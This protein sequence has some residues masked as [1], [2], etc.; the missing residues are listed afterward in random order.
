M[1]LY[2]VVTALLSAAAGVST[3]IIEMTVKIMVKAT[4]P[5]LKPG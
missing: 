5:R 2:L 3:A 4:L 1:I